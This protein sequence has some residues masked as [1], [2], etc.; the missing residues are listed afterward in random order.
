[1]DNSA[2]SYIFHPENAIDCSSFIDDPMDRELI[3]IGSF[4]KGIKNVDN[5]RGLSNMWREW[6]RIPNVRG[7]DF[8][9]NMSTSIG[10][11]GS[12]DEYDEDERQMSEP[13]QV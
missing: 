2:A 6:P 12:Y 1:M 9:R 8:P 10:I 5:V 7:V 13:V 3:Q 11:V 4:L